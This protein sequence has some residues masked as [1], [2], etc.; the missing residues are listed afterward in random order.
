MRSRQSRVRRTSQA[1]QSGLDVLLSEAATGGAPRFIAPGSAV[2]VGAGLARHPRRVVGRAA[3]LGAALARDGRRPLRAGARQGRPAFRRPRLERQLAV[4]PA[5][6][7]LPG[8]RRDRR[9]ADL[10]RRGRLARRAAGTARG[11]ERHRRGRPDEF[12]WSNPTV[13]KE[14][15]DTGGGNLVGGAQAS[16]PRPDHAA[17]PAGERRHEQVRSRRQCRGLARV[18]RAADRRVRADPVPPA[19]DQVLEVPLLFIPPTINRFYMLDISP[20]RSM[21]EYSS[22]RGSRCSRSRGAT[23]SSRAGSLRPR[24]LRRGGARGA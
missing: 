24:H 3:G 2:K 5:P 22:P 19:T 15:V 18:G 7:G 13:I 16:R 10:R 14:V 1:A 4:P 21:V 9:R 6:P 20:G 8:G 12:P 17:A 11:R 23:P